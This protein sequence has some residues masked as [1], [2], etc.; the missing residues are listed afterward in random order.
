MTFGHDLKSEIINAALLMSDVPLVRP[1]TATASYYPP[2]VHARHAQ[3]FRKRRLSRRRPENALTRHQAHQSRYGLTCLA[4]GLFPVP[5]LASY[6]HH[7]VSP[8]PRLRRRMRGTLQ[9]PQPG[10]QA[11]RGRSQRPAGALFLF[12]PCLQLLITSVYLRRIASQARR[13][14]GCVCVSLL[15]GTRY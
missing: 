3:T 12:F 11:Y 13:R 6:L 2:A 7:H 14:R 8:G 1:L 9:P 4:A 10:P 5:P 15:H